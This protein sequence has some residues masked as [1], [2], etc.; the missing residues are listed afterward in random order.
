MD[1]RHARQLVTAWKQTSLCKSRNST[2]WVK[3]HCNRWYS[4]LRMKC[5]IYLASGSLTSSDSQQNVLISNWT[6]CTS[7][8][9]LSGISPWQLGSCQ[10]FR[11]LCYKDFRE[12]DCLFWKLRIKWLSTVLA[13]VKTVIP[14]AQSDSRSYN[15]PTSSACLLSCTAQSQAVS[16]GSFSEGLS[17]RAADTFCIRV[18]DRMQELVMQQGN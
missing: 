1:A 16:V 6:P 12:P 11:W 9:A 3:W 8:T 18:S 13:I 15:L 17:S 10:L 4:G 7:E 2:L 5:I 14:S